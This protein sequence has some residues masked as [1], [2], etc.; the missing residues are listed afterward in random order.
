MPPVQV[1]KPWPVEV[2]DHSG[3][4]HKVTMEQGDMVLYEGA[5]CS[6]GREEPLDGDWFANVFV[7]M[8]PI[9]S[10]VPAEDEAR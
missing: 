3:G 1:N 7:H 6:H 2:V 9:D 8:A 5:S 10:P 4:V